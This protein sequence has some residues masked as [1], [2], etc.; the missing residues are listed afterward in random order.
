MK[1]FIT[2]ILLCIVSA[3]A[4]TKKADRTEFKNGVASG[5][6]ERMLRKKNS[7]SDSDL[8]CNCFAGVIVNDMSED[9]YLK[10]S[11]D[12]NNDKILLGI[13]IMNMEPL[14]QCENLAPN[15]KY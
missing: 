14:K 4:S 1:Y 11:R 2:I 13:M 5:C 3:C 12:T 10:A 6:A 7:K 9:E 15:A 8:F